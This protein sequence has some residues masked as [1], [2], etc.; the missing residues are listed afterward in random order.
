MSES[1]YRKYRPQTFDQV[2]GQDRGVSILQSFVSADAPPN[3]IIMKGTRGVGKTTLARIFARS[4]N[5]DP[6]DIYE[7]D[8]ASN[9]GV[10]DMRA[11]CDEALTMPILSQRKV[12]IFDEVHMFS[13]STWSVLLKMLEEPPSHVVFVMATTDDHKIPET[14]ISRSVVVALQQPN[15]ESLSAVIDRVAQAEDLVIDSAARDL[16]MIAADGSFRNALVALETVARTAIGNTIDE[17]HVA[18]TLSLP[19]AAYVRDMVQEFSYPTAG[20]LKA[21]IERAPLY[22]PLQTVKMVVAKTRTILEFRFQILKSSSSH[23]KEWLQ[24]IARDITGSRINAGVLSG[25]LR[26]ECDIAS[27]VEPGVV[28]EAYIYQLL[29]SIQ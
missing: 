22:N 9:N 28:L 8:A 1:F 7:L 16:I 24:A 23:D 6:I 14:I 10:D 12:Y 26:L 11:L 29:E 25:L 21:V 17:H 5:V 13:A 15:N 18:I 3:C 2:V 27:A 19:P 20:G 4:L